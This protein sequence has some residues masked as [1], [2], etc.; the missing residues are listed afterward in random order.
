MHRLR[1]LTILL[2]GVFAVAGAQA[3]GG[4]ASSAQPTGPLTGRWIIS[5]EYLGTPVNATM[6]LTQQQDK[7]TG[8]FD[9]DKLEGSV[10]GNSLH[11]LAKDDQGGSEEGTA[12]FE[13][14]SMAGTVI[15][16]D[17]TNPDASR[18]RPV[19][20]KSCQ[21]ASGRNSQDA[22]VHSHDLLS[23]VLAAQ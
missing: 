18:D 19:H 7:L 2:A 14:G 8:N 16:I 13:A 20:R 15:W 12:T 4:Q 10:T 21:A 9:G 5:A 6:E 22:R 11:F 17:G 1:L 3:Q 23:P